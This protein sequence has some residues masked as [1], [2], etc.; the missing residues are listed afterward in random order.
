MQW[1]VYISL[2][3]GTGSHL[4]E[5]LFLDIGVA[6]LAQGRYEFCGRV[7]ADKSKGYLLVSSNS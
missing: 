3:G 5:S 6:G 4:K 2:V 7:G 1:G